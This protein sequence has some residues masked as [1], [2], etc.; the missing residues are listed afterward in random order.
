MRIKLTN[1][2]TDLSR[3]EFLFQPLI[4]VGLLLSDGF[5]AVR[6]P[7]SG[8]MKVDRVLDWAP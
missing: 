5:A 4:T 2:V 7:R 3:S 6:I 1:R 8:A